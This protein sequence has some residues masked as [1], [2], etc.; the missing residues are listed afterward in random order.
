LSAIRDLADDLD[1]DSYFDFQTL[2][3]LATTDE[4]M[5]SLMFLSVSSYHKMNKHLMETERSHLSALVVT[6][7]W[8]EGL[9]LICE[10]NKF[11]EDKRLKERIAEQK[12]IIETLLN[13]L[14]FYQDKNHFKTLIDDIIRLK[15]IYDSIEQIDT[16][17]KVTQTIN[18]D[19]IPVIDQ[20]STS[21]L[22]MSDEHLQQIVSLVDEIRNKTIQGIK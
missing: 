7:V 18:E 19:G 14:V 3:R 6:G 15:V 1:V 20:G 21:E 8:L 2:K 10:V 11:Q 16:N 17:G 22:N 5:D 13:I 12:P 9:H 4:S